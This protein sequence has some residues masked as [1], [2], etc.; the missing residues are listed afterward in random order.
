M[1]KICSKCK[2]EKLF[3]EFAKDKRRKDGIQC[4]CKECDRKYRLQNKD[5]ITSTNKKYYEKNKSTILDQKKEYYEENKD[6]ILSYKAE[7][8]IKNSEIIIEKKKLY[9]Q[10]NPEVYRIWANENKDKIAAYAALR[11]ARKLQATPKWLSEDQLSEISFYYWLCNLMS[12]DND[13]K[14]HVDHIVP[15]QGKDVC[16]LHVP[17]N[18]QILEA[19]ENIRKSNKLLQ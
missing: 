6:S 7:Y 8:H 11:R 9:R 5:K 17:W 10:I 2:E 12:E 16:G 13:V 19:S 14:Y 1:Y 4:Q 18:L 3:S 15:L